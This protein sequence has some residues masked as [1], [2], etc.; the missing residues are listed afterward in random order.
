METNSI[1]SQIGNTPGKS[2]QRPQHMKR[3]LFPQTIQYPCPFGIFTGSSWYRDPG[4]N[5]RLFISKIGISIITRQVLPIESAC[6]YEVKFLYNDDCKVWTIFWIMASRACR[7]PYFLYARFFSRPAFEFEVSPSNE[8]V[9]NC[10]R[11]EK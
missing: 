6:F 7:I 10:I 3:V 2:I 9:H 8:G 5:G 1:I 4:F 11:V